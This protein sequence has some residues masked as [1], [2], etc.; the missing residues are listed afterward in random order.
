M[1]DLRK[2]L[3]MIFQHFSL[4]E[5]KTVFDNVALPLECFGYS[6]AEIKKSFRVIRSSW[7]IWK[8]KW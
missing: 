3:G 8:E 1:R 6:K 7:N 4:L 5:R 2:E